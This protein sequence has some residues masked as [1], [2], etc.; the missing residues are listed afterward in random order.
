M[1]FLTMHIIK[2]SL[3]T[4]LTLSCFMG[5]LYAEE[6]N[7]QKTSAVQ[8][9]LATAA[10]VTGCGLTVVGAVGVI[11]GF[12]AAKIASDMGLVK[13][14]ELIASSTSPYAAL[15]VPGLMLAVGAPIYLY[16]SVEGA[17][18]KK[19]SMLG[20]AA[21]IAGSALLFGGMGALYIISFFCLL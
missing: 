5:A 14:A 20:T 15:L 3:L 7:K 10:T 6:G 8:S 19:R 2:K 18:A 11:N 12:N 17:A 1:R 16:K 13:T 9:G 4:T 21:T